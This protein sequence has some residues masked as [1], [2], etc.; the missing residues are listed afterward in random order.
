MFLLKATGL[1]ALEPA[2]TT[3][4]VL[5]KSRTIDVGQT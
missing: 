4:S 2:K 3:K 5:P 1:P